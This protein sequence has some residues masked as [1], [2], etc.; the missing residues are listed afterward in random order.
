MSN[1]VATAQ[2]I[3]SL[4]SARLHQQ[5]SSYQHHRDVV[6]DRGIGQQYHD[7]QQGLGEFSAHDQRA[8]QQGKWGQIYFRESFA[9]AFFI[10]LATSTWAGFIASLL[11]RITLKLRGANFFTT[12]VQPCAIDFP[13]QRY[14]VVFLHHAI[15]F[16]AGFEFTLPSLSS[17]EPAEVLTISSPIQVESWA[18]FEVASRSKSRN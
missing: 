15:S 18:Q 4:Q 10:F 8:R 12:A 11:W 9:A 17:E 7:V 13:K 3:Q 14:F 16:V 5:I 6:A 2:T 1:L